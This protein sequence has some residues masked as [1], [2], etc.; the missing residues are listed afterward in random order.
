MHAFFSEKYRIILNLFRH[1]R[2]AYSNSSKNS[3]G[4]LGY[5]GN[6]AVNVCRPRRV[7]IIPLGDKRKL[8]GG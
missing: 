3:R 5:T 7:K 8:P 4:A 1:K 2:K 6:Y